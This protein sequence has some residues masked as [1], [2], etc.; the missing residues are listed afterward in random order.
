MKKTIT[1]LSI[2]CISYFAFAHEYILLAYKYKVQKGDTL[3]LHLVVADGFNIQMERQVQKN[4]IK[5]FELINENGSTNLLVEAVD[6]SL[7]I[8]NKKVDFEG[9]GLIHLERNYARISLPTNKFLSYLKEDH[10]ENIVVTDKDPTKMQ[11]ERYS[12]YIKTLVQSGAKSYGD[13]FKK[14]VGQNLEIVLLQ[15]PYLLQKGE[16]LKAQIL[17][18][19]KP[20]VNKI[21]TARNRKGN[22]SAG[23]LTSRTDTNGICSFKITG[24]GEWFIHLTQMIPCPQPED[25]DWESFWAS[26]SF[27]IGV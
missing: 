27:Q 12:R 4:M 8:L 15:N 18:M 11:R 22:E 5:R 17:F 19:G 13:E 20:L 21:V 2:L 7:P 10:I 9:L 23:V 16:T 6:Q 25:S 3:E 24:N 14:V 26:Y 1:I